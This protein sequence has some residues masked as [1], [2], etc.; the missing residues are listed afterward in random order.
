MKPNVGFTDRMIRG[1]AGAAL[2]AWAAFGGPV[3]AWLGIVPLA[4]AIFRFCPAYAPFGIS[5]CPA[6]GRTE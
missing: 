1:I 4:T 5:T 3:W 2:M 6:E